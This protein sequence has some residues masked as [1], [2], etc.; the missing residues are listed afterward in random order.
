MI[1]SVNASSDGCCCDRGEN[2]E[3][4]CQRHLSAKT[5]VNK[6][7]PCEAVVVREQW[8]AEQLRSRRLFYAT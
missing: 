7:G 5:D 4:T 8:T 3:P 6:V 2:V 1:Q